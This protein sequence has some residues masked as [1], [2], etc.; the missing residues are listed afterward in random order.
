MT[1]FEPTKDKFIKE[2]SIKDF[3]DFTDGWDIKVE[4]CTKGGQGWGWITANRE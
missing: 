1:K 4:R 3:T 2:F